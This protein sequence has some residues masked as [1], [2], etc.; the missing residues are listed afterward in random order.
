MPYIELRLNFVNNYKMLYFTDEDKKYTV[1]KYDLGRH[2]LIK[3]L[4]VF[5]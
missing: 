3:D 1:S 2:Y 4:F 5:K